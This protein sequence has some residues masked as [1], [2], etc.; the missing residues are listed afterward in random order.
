MTITI[1]ALSLVRF[2]LLVIIVLLFIEVIRTIFW[3]KIYTYRLWF[4]LAALTFIVG[5]FSKIVP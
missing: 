3:V 2:A 5:L 4:I 1:T